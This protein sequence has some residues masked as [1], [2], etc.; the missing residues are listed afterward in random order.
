MDLEQIFCFVV[1]LIFRQVPVVAK[2]YVNLQQPVF[3]SDFEKDPH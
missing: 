3:P 2:K 1:D